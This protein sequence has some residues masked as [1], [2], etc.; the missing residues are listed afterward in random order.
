HTIINNSQFRNPILRFLLIFFLTFS[1]FIHCKF[2][3]HK[4]FTFLPK[5]T[6]KPLLRF[7]L[8]T[9]SLRRRCSTYS[10]KA[11]SILY[12]KR[13]RHSFEHPRPYLFSPSILSK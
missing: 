13:R 9:S 8:G 12:Q 1:N 2:M 11:A 6:T 5:T 7:E 3:L 4:I 10:A